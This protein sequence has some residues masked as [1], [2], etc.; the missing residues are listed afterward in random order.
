MR[1]GARLCSGLHELRRKIPPRGKSEHPE[2]CFWT[3]HRVPLFTHRAGRSPEVTSLPQG[4]W[5]HTSAASTAHQPC[6]YLKDEHF[7]SGSFPNKPLT[8]ADVPGSFSQDLG[9]RDPWPEPLLPPLFI[10]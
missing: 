10:Q 5:H 6:S 4:P 2:L 9:G 1:A 3:H 7:P 8:R